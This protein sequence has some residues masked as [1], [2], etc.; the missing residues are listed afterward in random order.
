[1]KKYR[2]SDYKP[3]DFLIPNI[4]LDFNLDEHKTD[5]HAQF[6]VIRNNTQ[7][8][9]LVLDGSNLVL[10]SVTLNGKK[11][12]P[13]EYQQ[14]QEQLIIPIEGDRADLVLHTQIHPI[15]NKALTG[16]YYSH[17]I[18]TTQCEA[19][20]FR[21]ITY[22]L[23][24]PDVLSVYT[25]TLT[26][27]AHRYPTLLSNGNLIQKDLTQNRLQVC[28]YDPFPKPCYLFAIVAGQLNSLE[29]HFE[30]CS[31]K[32]VN[33][34]I[35]SQREIQDC[36]YAMD[37]LKQAMRWDEQHYG[38]QYDLEN[39]ALVAIAD[40][41]MGAMENK[42]LNIF[43]EQCVF[44]DPQMTTDAEYET[45][46]SVVAHEYFH[47]W[48]GNRVTCRDWFQ[49]SLKEGLTVFREHEFIAAFTSMLSRID[50]VKYLRTN[51]FKE[52]SGPLAHP[53]QPQE[54][55]E[56]DNF[57]TQTVYEKGAEVIRMLQLILGDESFHRGMDLYFS[58]HD[59]QAVTI[60]D[61]LR[62]MEDANQA[63]LTQFRRW[64]HQAGTPILTV[65][66][67]YVP[68][69]QKY[70]LT[71]HQKLQPTP[72]Q[73][74]K[75]PMVVPI[76]MG[77]LSQDGLS[78]GLKFS[79]EA[80]A[81]DDRVLQ[82]TQATETFEFV[83][84]P[85]KPIP[86]LLRGFSAP[87]KLE[88]DYDLDEL[89]VLIRYDTDVFNRWEAS[90][91]LAS[92]LLLSDIESTQ[93]QP[94]AL[95][96]LTSLYGELLNA[97][98]DSGLLAEL[99]TLPTQDHLGEQM[100]WIDVAAIHQVHC[101]W[102][103][104]IAQKLRDQLLS[105]Y[106]A[107]LGEQYVYTPAAVSKR[108]LKN[109][110]LYYL[111]AL[112]DSEIQA[113]CLSQYEQSDNMTDRLHALKLLLDSGYQDEACLGDF[114][115]RASNHPSILNKWLF[116]QASCERSDALDRV[117]RLL[118][119]P[120]YDEKNPNNVRALIYA[121]C[122][123]NLVQF[124]RADGLGYQFLVDQILKIDQFNPHLSAQLIRPLTQWKRYIKKQG[125][126]MHEQ[127]KFLIGQP[128]SKNLFEIVDKSLQ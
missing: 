16:L 73:S 88:I 36:R 15:E 119:H 64:Y 25:T 44:S 99:I 55:I 3:P 62:A 18:L 79:K 58:R 30:T 41:N 34:R 72:G 95:T 125:S 126:L 61:F 77:L 51:Q 92:I 21:R 112:S 24:R 4:F 66:Q 86:S 65:Q 22:F 52:D 124:H 118:N 68:E 82:L 71:I 53:V 111:M 20:G 54:Y 121:F 117:K 116:V 85:S 96:R 9:D 110:C 102:R 33:L 49:L 83:E 59:G 97:D 94:E 12:E 1:M 87:V 17:G 7:A 13:N 32:K 127:L 104:N 47:N 67:R 78:L 120:C 115:H 75:K 27:D 128:L 76:K 40:F 81:V 26:A 69:E 2:L 114:Y 31:G 90:Q 107:N 103:I 123:K 6:E 57:Y 89:V 5:V 63:D 113:L 42:G 48:T 38:R 105:T 29:D 35:F 45:V 108:R 70:L 101:Q 109:I 37:A 8:S 14:T 122:T 91:K 10:I 100:Q 84:I 56:I 43:N 60:E 46:L 28:W 11:L 98:L 23:D 74:D 39:Y 50:Q 106:Q 19:Q 93:I 80:V